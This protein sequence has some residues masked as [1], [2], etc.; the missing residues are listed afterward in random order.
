MQRWVDLRASL[1]RGKSG[2]VLGVWSCAGGGQALRLSRSGSRGAPRPYRQQLTA[3][4]VEIGQSKHGLR[5]RQVLGQAT[6]AYFGEAPQLLDDPKR[7]LAAGAGPRARPIDHAPALAQRRAIGAPIDSVAHTLS[8]ER[9]AIGF[10][11]VSLIAEHLPF[12]PVQ[13]M[14]KLGDIRHARVG[15]D[16]GMDDAALIRP[17]VQLHS[18]IPVATF[19]GLLHLGVASRGRVL[20][21]LG[22]AMMV[23]STM[24]P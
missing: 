22:A 18:E 12:L 17:D 4:L 7:M 16:H 5:P 21:E 23:A 11:P 9:L 14:R 13:Q 24:V 20:V 1:I 2:G 10:L 15:R 8:R 3:Q 19:A 6:V